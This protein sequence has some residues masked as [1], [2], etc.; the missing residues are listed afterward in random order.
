[1]ENIQLNDAGDVVACD[2][3]TLDEPIPVAEFISMMKKTRQA[4]ELYFEMVMKA[5]NGLTEFLKGDSQAAMLA[6]NFK[7]VLTNSFATKH[8]VVIHSF[9]PVAAESAAEEEEEKN[10]TANEDAALSAADLHLK[11]N[12]PSE[13]R[14]R[15]KEDALVQ[16]IVVLCERRLKT[17]TR[18]RYERPDDRHKVSLTTNELWEDI[19]H[20]FASANM[21]EALDQR[22]KPELPYILAAAGWR[23]CKAMKYSDGIVMMPFGQGVPGCHWAKSPADDHPFWG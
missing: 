16:Q 6:Q 15:V 23:A 19:E 18:R 14:D 21:A 9:T 1:M 8:G 17:A 13:W 22:L 11:Y 5:E 4:V 12:V 3:I 20:I 7:D 2:G 10:S